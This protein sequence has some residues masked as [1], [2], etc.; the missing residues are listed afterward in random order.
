MLGTRTVAEGR[1]PSAQVAAATGA[2]A[3]SQDD[4]VVRATYLLY[5]VYL[6]DAW[7]PHPNLTLHFGVRYEVDTRKEPLPTDKNNLSVVQ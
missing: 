5:G 3:K 4:P 2:A 1:R 7:K 6:Q